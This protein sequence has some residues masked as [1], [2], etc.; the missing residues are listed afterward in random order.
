MHE[1]QERV[2][3]GPFVQSRS[4]FARVALPKG[5]YCFIPSTFDPGQE[6]RFMMRFYSASAV[7]YK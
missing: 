1:K 3:A 2:H 4:V 5:I 7:T 6:G